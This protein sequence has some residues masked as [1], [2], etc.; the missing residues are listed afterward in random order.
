M[1]VGSLTPPSIEMDHLVDP[2]VEGEKYTPYGPPSKDAGD[3]SPL[4]CGNKILAVG[5]AWEGGRGGERRWEGGREGGVRV[6]S[7]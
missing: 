3:S 2:D 7:Q 1:R 6:S 5:A 4:S